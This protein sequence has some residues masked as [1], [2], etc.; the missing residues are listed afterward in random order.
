MRP[1]WL[2]AVSLAGAIAAVPALAQDMGRPLFAPSAVAVLDQESFFARSAFGRKV[3]AE[4]EADTT[5]LATENRQLEQ[6]LGDAERA[7]LE[8]RAGLDPDEFRARADAFDARVIETRAQQDRKA[9]EITRRVEAARAGF[10][11]A[12][13]PVL[14]ELM[15][16]R[17]HS[18]VLDG[19]AVLLS[20][21]S[22]D[23]TDAAI[24]AVDA[25]IGESL[26]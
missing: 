11:E 25:R 14:L 7:L 12:A 5:A 22:A 18:V 19:R 1:V 8:A 16:E 13:V 20:F 23:I 21:E 3:L 9:V 24:A 15:R 4:A 6:E 17:G 26:P 2:A 10:F